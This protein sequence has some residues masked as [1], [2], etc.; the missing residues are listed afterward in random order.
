MILRD[1][2]DGT[3]APF[4]G[5]RELLLRH[6]PADARVVRARATVTPVNA[7]GEETILFGGAAGDWG[8]TKVAA[9]GWVEV[10]FHARRTLAG[11]QGS[12]L[13][14]TTL[15]VDFGGGFIPINAQGT[16]KAPSD[17]DFPIPGD[18]VILPGLTV[19]RFR[20]TRAGANPDVSAVRVRSAPA[21]LTLAL[22]GQPTFWFHPGELTRPA[23]TPDFGLLLQAY[24]D[25]LA[26]VKDGVFLLPFLL[27]SDSIARLAVEVEIEYLRRVSVL[28]AGV[29]DAVLPFDHG[30]LPKAGGLRVALPAD[31]RVVAGSG[32]AAGAFRE[33]RIAFGPTGEVTPLGTLPVAAGSTPAHPVLLPAAVE[34]VAIDLLL[35]S[36]TRTARLQLDLRQNLDGKP[37]GESFLPAP[38]PFD[39]DREM[40]GHPTWVSVPLPAPFQFRPG[41]ER[42]YWMV[43][44]SLDGEAAWS[45]ETAAPALLSMQ[46]TQDGGFSWRQAALAGQPAH[47]AGL[48]RLRYRPA[49]FRMPVELQVGSGASARRV[50][51]SRFEPQGRVDLDLDLSEIA[52]AFNEV[53]SVAPGRRPE[54]EH[55]ANS[56]FE[57]WLRVGDRLGDPHVIP[58]SEEM[59]Q[60]ARVAASPDGR[61]AYVASG[62]ANGSLFQAVDLDL[63]ETVQTS[64]LEPGTVVGLA[65]SPDGRLAYVG[66]SA[67]SDTAS[68]LERIQVIDLG[69]LEP[70]GA[71]RLSTDPVARLRSLALSADGRRLSA[72]LNVSAQTGVV[73]Q[74]GCRLLALDT[75]LLLEAV[76]RGDADAS[77]ALLQEELVS[78]VEP[79]DLAVSPDGTR[80][81]LLGSGADG[82]EQILIAGEQGLE[83]QHDLTIPLGELGV[84]QRIALTPDGATA[85]VVHNQGTVLVDLASRRVLASFTDDGISV[86]AA[87]LEPDGARVFLAGAEGFGILDLVRRISI[88]DPVPGFTPLALDVAVTPAGERILLVDSQALPGLEG[89]SPGLVVI[90]LGDARPAGWTV[91]AGQVRRFTLAGPL[92]RIAVLG[93]IPSGPTG[94]SPQSSTG[95]HAI[96]QVVPVAP[97]TYEL[98]FHAIA[99]EDDAVAEVIWRGEGCGLLRQDSV[100]I[101]KIGATESALPVHRARLAAPAG[102]TQAEARFTAAGGAVVISDVSL[103]ATAAAVRNRDL[104]MGDSLGG[105]LPEG[106][107]QIPESAA[108]FSA[109]PEGEAVRLRNLGLREAALSQEVA[110]EAGRSF[111]LE[112]QG[113]TVPAAAPAASGRV[114]LRWLSGSG[115]E[116]APPV[117]LEARPDGFGTLAA[118]GVVPAGA[119]RAELRLAVPPGA[120]LDIRQV[121]LSFAEPAQVP[122]TFVAQAPGELAV[123]DWELAYDQVPAPL[124]AVPAGALCTPTPPPGAPEAEGCCGCHGE[125]AEGAVSSRAQTAA[126]VRVLHLRELLPARREARAEAAPVTVIDGIGRGRARQLQEVGIRTLHHLAAASPAKLRQALRGV[127]EAQAAGLILKARAALRQ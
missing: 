55:L 29:R 100:P 70:L 9:P 60:N 37:D 98:S 50:G 116:A 89:T 120:A 76:Q 15:Q 16:F 125:P 75:A 101:A 27:H 49:T 10:D 122:V 42:T 61:W 93:T 63:E 90:P 35:T 112:L 28:P 54:G 88:P 45:V 26:E 6:L 46:L 39:L 84:P 20:L 106:W 124:P 96:S 34:A 110:A 74:S 5:D 19:S 4:E 118:H 79:A 127:S 107:R 47:L 114:E 21:N 80:L 33:D 115:T 105:G 17:S 52:G 32:R 57:R 22:R 25:D 108:G 24:L 83:V 43:L 77:A 109:L 48:F 91:T 69:T 68:A 78:L 64:G 113:R 31:A 23:A 58:L 59:S 72:A 8:A 13:A 81:Y 97:G 53:L 12:N 14:N 117:L 38:V 56:D 121:D 51:L 103:R 3:D 41:Q 65:V 2:Y 95:P 111:S 66:L 40:A 7:G 62:R 18:S 11:V 86:V 67:V 94:E 85:V 102:A 119:V 92:S 99:S 44:Q 126:S 30:S 104:R 71:L 87:A 36:I 73:P 1:R 123:L 82:Q